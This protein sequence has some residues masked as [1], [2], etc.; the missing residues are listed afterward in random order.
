MILSLSVRPIMDNPVA[1]IDHVIAV[2]QILSRTAK[3][4]IQKI[5]DLPDFSE[6]LELLT[7]L[8]LKSGRLFKVRVCFGVWLIY[9]Y[10]RLFQGGT[11]DL[12]AAARQ[13]LTDWNHQKIPYF[14]IPPTVH[15]SSI[16]STSKFVPFL[17]L[18]SVSIPI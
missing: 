7:M 3:E 14:S 15:P 9:V 18:M 16:P 1:A 6:T 11:P 4:A 8:A 13:V 5:Y 12:L 17:C 10:N 2:E